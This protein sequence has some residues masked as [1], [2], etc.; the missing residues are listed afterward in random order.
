[1][2][3]TRSFYKPFPVF[4][5][6][7][8]DA[9]DS[10]RVKHSTYSSDYIQDNQPGAP[11]SLARLNYLNE[12]KTD[13]HR[14]DV[15]KRWHAKSECVGYDNDQNMEPSTW[16]HLQTHNLGF[17]S[18]FERSL[19]EIVTEA[20][21]VEKARVAMTSTN[22]VTNRQRELLEQEHTGF[23]ANHREELTA[24]CFKNGS[25]HGVE[26]N[27]WPILQNDTTPALMKS[28]DE[29]ARTSRMSSANLPRW[30]SLWFL[31]STIVMIIDLCILRL[32]TMLSEGFPL[33]R[34]LADY[35]SMSD[36]IHQP[37]EV[38]LQLTEIILNGVYLVLASL[39][40]PQALL[41]AFA[42]VVFTL[43]QT[44]SLCIYAYLYSIY[45]SSPHPSIISWVSFLIFRVMIPSGVG[46]VVYG[47]I[48]ALLT[49]KWIQR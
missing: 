37:H 15:Q 12:F 39:G 32:G 7:H 34:V 31:T 40:W 35:W 41:L 6:T 22:I 24:R 10:S 1:M 4:S 8:G 20:Q 9:Q 26:N 44:I 28:K 48:C 25:G 23:S 47:E 18:R 30:V 19:S 13:V 43:G 45:L 3:N 33:K 16:P 2:F 29:Q 17:S 11:H 42:S 49:V 36:L 5:A 46:F 21:E 38:I 27:N 14:L